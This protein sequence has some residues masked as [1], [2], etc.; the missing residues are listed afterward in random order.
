MKTS[1]FVALRLFGS[2]GADVLSRI[3]LEH[4]AL[5]LITHKLRSSSL[6]FL[7]IIMTMA[8]KRGNVMDVNFRARGF[9]SPS[10]HADFYDISR[11][12][13]KKT[14]EQGNLRRGFTAKD[15]VAF[16]D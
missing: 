9:I 8:V 2:G 16:D 13:V 3:Y 1:L 10:A 14:T 7:E 4:D 6:K 5:L 11:D 15:L 12:G